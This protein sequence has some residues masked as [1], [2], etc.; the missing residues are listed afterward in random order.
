ML[1]LSAQCGLADC[2]AIS[3]LPQYAADSAS[4]LFRLFLV[5]G[6]SADSVWNTVESIRASVIARDGQYIHVDIN[7]IGD[8]T[9]TKRLHSVLVE[10]LANRPHRI[11]L[12]IIL[13]HNPHSASP[14][15]DRA[16][17]W[18]GL[19]DL[20]LEDDNPD[21]TTVIVLENI[22][23]AS[24]QIQHE[25]A[26][27]IRLHKTHRI[28]RTFYATTQQ[29]NLEKLSAELLEHAEIVPLPKSI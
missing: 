14:F 22:D 20:I 27:L 10:V 25:I 16:I 5:G 17:I 8:S 9:L 21:R 1:T 24:P 12:P 26:R 4:E 29:E 15:I 19:C 6:D 3:A 28:N 23:N 13:Q 11:Q 7:D 18:Q 2:Q